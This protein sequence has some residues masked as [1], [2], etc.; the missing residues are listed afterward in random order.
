VQSDLLATIS[1]VGGQ[2]LWERPWWVTASGSGQGPSP[3]PTVRGAL[4]LDQLQAPSVGL[5][6]FLPSPQLKKEQALNPVSH[7]GLQQLIT[8]RLGRAPG[9][10][11][12]PLAKRSMGGVLVVK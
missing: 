5:W 9:W 12:L 6:L 8:G 4:K 1:S 2:H 7:F 3:S 10:C 11:L